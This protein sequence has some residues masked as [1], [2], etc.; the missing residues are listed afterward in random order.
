M[1]AHVFEWLAKLC[2]RFT[3][4]EIFLV[5]KESKSFKENVGPFTDFQVTKTIAQMEDL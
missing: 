1:Q 2:Q 3:Q 4:C 5:S